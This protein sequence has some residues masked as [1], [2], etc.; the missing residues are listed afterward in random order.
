MERLSIAIWVEP[1]Y[2][3]KKSPVSERCLGRGE[4]DFLVY[5]VKLAT[6]HMIVF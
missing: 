2:F 1:G 5:L 3:M 4:V 6:V